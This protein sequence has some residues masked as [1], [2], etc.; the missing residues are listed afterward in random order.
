MLPRSSTSC[1]RR[2]LGGPVPR[3]HWS[4]PPTGE[5]PHAP[6]R[7]RA[8]DRPGGEPGRTRPG[9]AAAPAS[10]RR[11]GLGPG[12]LRVAPTSSSCPTRRLRVSACSLPP[13]ARG[14][15][16]RPST[17]EVAARRRSAARG[18]GASRVGAPA[19][20]ATARPSRRPTCA[21]AEAGPTSPTRVI[22]G[23]GLAVVAPGLP[24]SSAATRPR[25]SRPPSSVAAFE[26][27]EA[28]Q[29]AGF[30]PATL[31]GLLRLE[32][33]S[34]RIAYDRGEFVFPL[35]V[36]LVIV[37]TLLWYLLEVVRA[38]PVVNVAVTLM[39]FVVRRLPRRLRRPVAHLP[40][41]GVGLILGRRALRVFGYDIVGYFVGSQ[42]GQLRSRRHLAQQDDRGPDRRHGRAR[43]SLG[44]IVAGS[45]ADAVERAHRR[46]APRPRRRDHG[47]GSATSA[48]R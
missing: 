12:R 25:S 47:A 34:C 8:V 39:G 17:G 21:A 18:T 1:R 35:I 5:I 3:P 42:F 46:R 32:S 45:S 30:R 31:L 26:L 41:N 43:S 13:A 33:R 24:R 44:G 40:P 6:A 9:R 37:F 36:V 4:E 27:F 29:R 2:R 23:V 11:G 16:H 10:D 38:R 14:R 20:A 19:A 7:G 28:F 48:S 15:R 22:T